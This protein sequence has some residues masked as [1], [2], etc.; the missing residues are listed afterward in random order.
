M[1]L[2]GFCVCVFGCMLGYVC[3]CMC[4]YECVCVYECGYLLVCV[5]VC[6]YVVGCVSMRVWLVLYVWLRP[7]E[8]VCLRLLG[9]CSNR[10]KNLQDHKTFFVKYD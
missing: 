8:S 7:I 10:T 2:C 3:V 5:C 9:C 4:K 1:G 6:V